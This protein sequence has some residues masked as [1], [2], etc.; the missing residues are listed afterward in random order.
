MRPYTFLYLPDGLVSAEKLTDVID[1]VL[2]IV[3][4]AGIVDGEGQQYEDEH[5]R[6]WA[7]SSEIVVWLLR[8]DEAGQKVTEVLNCYR[9]EL[10]DPYE[11]YTLRV[12]KWMDYLL[13][14]GEEVSA[15]SEYSDDWH[16]VMSDKVFEPVDDADFDDYRPVLKRLSDAPIERVRHDLARTDRQIRIMH[17]KLNRF[18]EKLGIRDWWRIEG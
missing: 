15:Q 7:G 2:A 1:A 14:L 12:G 13:R 6:L 18:M 11:V 8:P 17:A 10:G 3:Y 4:D 9:K 5:L 16:E